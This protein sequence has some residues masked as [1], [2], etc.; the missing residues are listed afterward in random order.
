MKSLDYVPFGKDE[1]VNQVF[2]RNNWSK[3][4]IV[5]D[6]TGSMSPYTK[7]LLRWFSKNIETDK[8]SSFTFF[9]DGDGMPDKKKKIGEV[10]G[11]Y[12]TSTKSMDTLANF[13]VRVMKKGDGD[14]TPENNLEAAIEAAARFPG[15]ELVIL[16]GASPFMNTAYLQLAYET[17]GSVH[18]LYEDIGNLNG[19]P[20]GSI[21]N[22]G[23]FQYRLN[24][25]RFVKEP[26]R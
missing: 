1:V 8:I 12:H 3:M 25:G 21:I 4:A 13:I 16:C 26:F 18:T 9:N 14:D 23:I 17:G 2:D 7:Q 19:L 6:V 5:C 22:F 11:I 15:C 24:N 10:G 20:N